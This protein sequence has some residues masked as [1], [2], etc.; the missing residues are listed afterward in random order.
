MEQMLRGADDVIIDCVNTA[1]TQK[2]THYTTC[3]ETI[4][5]L[6][7]SISRIVRFWWGKTG[8]EVDPIHLISRGLAKYFCTRF[9]GYPSQYPKLPL[10]KLAFGG[11]ICSPVFP[12][13][14]LREAIAS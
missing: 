1:T 13:S 4:L 2:K 5:A 12:F 8:A 10:S 3:A 6:T 11:L 7:L 14:K 9:M